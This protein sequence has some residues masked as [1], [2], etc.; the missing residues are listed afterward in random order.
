[1]NT[2]QDEYK[3]NNK[4]LN[5]ENISV[6]HKGMLLFLL[7]I[8]GNYIGN[9][10]S[11]RTQYLF[12]NN[13][14]VKHLI[15]FISLYFFI[16]LV[17]LDINPFKALILSIPMYFYFIMLTKS[18]STF[19]VSII[20]LLI[21]LVFLHNYKSYLDKKKKLSKIELIYI[22]N[23]NIV[24]KIVIG[25]ILTFTLMGF[26]IYL[27]MKKV[28]YK[29]NFNLKDFLFGKIVCKNNF[30]GEKIALTPSDINLK[31][32]IYFLKKAFK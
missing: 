22:K 32:Y 6:I 2:I 11:C 10:V 13:I 14:Y 31:L 20:I 25:I 23:I 17:E 15:G 19:F 7:I 30:L 16:I 1:M 28:E 12:N 3:E 27:G 8:S 9:L 26:L 24:R 5:L 18:Q 21:I 4:I 29:N